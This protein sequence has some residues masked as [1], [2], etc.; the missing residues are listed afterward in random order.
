[1]CRVGQNHIYTPYMAV[2][3][4]IS[5]PKIPYM[6]HISGLS[7][8]R[9][10]DFHASYRTLAAKKRIEQPCRISYIP[11]KQLLQH[12]SVERKTWER[13]RVWN[14]PVSRNICSVHNCCSIHQSYEKHGGRVGVASPVLRKACSVCMRL[15]S[16]C[17]KFQHSPNVQ[18]TWRACGRDLSCV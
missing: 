16:V 13:A 17:V 10:T 11:Y 1:M 6:H 3:L 2:N 8:F 15:C 5:L 18:K 4:V 9:F 7:S 14:P 12:S